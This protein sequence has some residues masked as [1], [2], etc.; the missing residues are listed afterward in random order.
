MPNPKIG[1]RVCVWPAP[2][3]RVLEMPGR[4]FPAKIP[5]EG[6]EVSW[7]PFLEQ[8]F[9]TGEIHLHDPLPVVP[10]SVATSRKP[11]EK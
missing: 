1:D 6:C 9:R 2:G 11:E 8:R 5:A 10:Q 7:S 4:F 3:L